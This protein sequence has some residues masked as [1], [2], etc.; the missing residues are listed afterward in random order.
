MS[1]IFLLSSIGMSVIIFLS[2]FDMSVIISSSC[3]LG[4]LWLGQEEW[5]MVVVQ[6]EAS[7]S[8]AIDWRGNIVRS[9]SC[10]HQQPNIGFSGGFLYALIFLFWMTGMAGCNTRT[11]WCSE[12][13]LFDRKVKYAAAASRGT[14]GFAQWSLKCSSQRISENLQNSTKEW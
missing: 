9:C 11:R 14:F 4:N 8:K 3:A 7:F 1:V 2:S 12:V 6:R 13:L 5:I 10:F